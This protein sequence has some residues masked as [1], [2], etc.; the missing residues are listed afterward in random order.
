[1]P[2]KGSK[3]NIKDKPKQKTPTT[4]AHDS[5]ETET[6]L[7]SPKKENRKDG[8]SEE[9]ISRPEEP[10]KPELELSA[11]RRSPRLSAQRS[12]LIPKYSLPLIQSPPLPIRHSR[13]L[14]AQ[15]P[16]ILP[17]L[18][19]ALPITSRQSQHQPGR[20]PS[21]AT[22]S[23]YTA[24]SSPIH[25]SPAE[26]SSARSAMDTKDQPDV[27]ETENTVTI[28]EIPSSLP[29]ERSPSD[30]IGDAWP[31]SQ[32]DS[33]PI[34]LSQRSPFQHSQPRYEDG[35]RV[36]DPPSSKMSQ[37]N[38][39]ETQS[40][41][42]QP[43]ARSQTSL[44]S[45]QSEESQ[46]P[47]HASQNSQRRISDHPATALDDTQSQED[48]SVHENYRMAPPK[49]S[50]YAQQVNIFR[51]PNIPATSKPVIDESQNLTQDE[52][53]DE[54][55]DAGKK[56]K[57]VDSINEI[58]DSAPKSLS[59]LPRSPKRMYSPK[60]PADDSCLVLSES[61]VP[62]SMR[63]KTPEYINIHSTQSQSQE[64]HPPPGPRPTSQDLDNPFGAP[65]TDSEESSSSLSQP[66]GHNWDSSQVTAS[67]VGPP[68]DLSSYPIPPSQFEL[69]NQTDFHPI[70]ESLVMKLDGYRTGS[71][72][73]G[74][75]DLHKRED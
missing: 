16:P 60:S 19:P 18:S 69:S 52:S 72:L 62:S 71:V 49:Q 14:L 30:G 66:P 43:H 68:I 63:K 40:Q 56:R 31:S 24:F 8:D 58:P 33:S 64:Y 35:F 59:Q 4:V 28:K 51:V 67:P 74:L 50:T 73:D 2:R 38:L 29:W 26:P 17:S 48:P 34:R 9:N 11:S 55:P 25:S 42:S 41:E 75:S 15:P 57:R 10:S 45:T 61:Q 13:P 46:T 44:G 21:E 3:V 53:L 23:Y 22:A 32:S 39:G 36:P 5:I 20:S 54:Q 6:P 47:S 65:L 12:K 7:S 70:A 27:T 37:M 1:M